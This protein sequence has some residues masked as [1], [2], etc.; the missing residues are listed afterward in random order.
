MKTYICDCGKTF[1]EPN[2]FNA[3]KNHCII[4][5][6]NCNKYN[7]LLEANKKRSDKLKQYY[8]NKKE[9]AEEQ[10]QKELQNWISEQHTC[11]RCGKVMIEKF[12]SGRFCSRSCAN[13]KGKILSEQ[14]KENIRKGVTKNEYCKCSFCNKEFYNLTA[15]KV[16]E[17]Y[18][19]N[20]PDHVKAK[21][22]TNH[23]RK[24]NRLYKI[25]PQETL[26]VTYGFVE[27][28]MIEHTRC[29]ICGKTLEETIKNRGKYTPKKL[30]VDHDHI[31]HKFRGTLCT[32]C[33]R[34][35]GWYE[36]N[37]E[38]INKYLNKD[39]PGDI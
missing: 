26:D 25:T 11:E 29:E 38:S 12:G 8:I 6:K 35:L 3:H 36:N 24:L 7:D 28:Y 17:A 2:K 16:H 27:K 21:N 15:S 30:C 22:N 39:Y 33:N 14:Q 10:K 32:L 18:C 31:N 5:M 9:K 37:K 13:G 19:K 20:N 1:T 34:Q 4:H 23:V